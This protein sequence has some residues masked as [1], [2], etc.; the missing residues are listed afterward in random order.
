MRRVVFSGSIGGVEG[1]EGVEV[2]I[3]AGDAVEG[4]AFGCAVLGTYI[5]SILFLRVLVGARLPLV[6]YIIIDLL[7]SVLVVASLP[8]RRLS[9]QAQGVG[10]I[11][12]EAFEQVVID[13]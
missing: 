2:G 11:V 6:G 3:F 10:I 1:G 7:C 5:I 4:V 9:E 13:W 8:R 12:A